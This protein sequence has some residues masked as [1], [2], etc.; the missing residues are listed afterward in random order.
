M[1]S[2]VWLHIRVKHL[3]TKRKYLI[4]M[5]TKTKT[6]TSASKASKS[7]TN[8]STAPVGGTVAT[9]ALYPDERRPNDERIS[10]YQGARVTE[11]TKLMNTSVNSPENADAQAYDEMPVIGSPS[12]RPYPPEF[13]YVTQG[14][15]DRKAQG[16]PIIPE[17]QQ[18][19]ENLQDPHAVNRTTKEAQLVEGFHK[20]PMSHQYSLDECKAVGAGGLIDP[21]SHM[22]S[23]RSPTASKN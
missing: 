16:R 6:T 8:T 9:R 21:E 14:Q 13:E 1:L 23:Y 7:K 18:M 17:Y 12:E 20:G 4:I 10:Q 3:S 22:Q 11:N 2:N 5:A 15:E 19:N